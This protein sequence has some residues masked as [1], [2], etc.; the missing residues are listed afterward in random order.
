MTAGAP[1]GSA[2]VRYPDVGSRPL[3]NTRAWWLVGLNFLVPGSAQVLA[4]NRRLGR[5]GLGSTLLFWALV[6]VVVVA[7]LIARTSLLAILLTPVVLWLITAVLAFYGVVWLICTLDTLRLV[8]FVRLGGAVR[9]GVAVLAVAALVLSGGVAF[10]GAW[11]TG[12]TAIVAGKVASNTVDIPGGKAVGPITGAVNLLLVGSDS[13]GGNAAYGTRGETLNDVTILLRISPTS[14]SATALSIPRDLYGSQPACTTSSGE[15]DPPVS[16]ARFNTA[17]ARGGLPCVAGAA[18]AL[19]GL[20]VDYAALIQFDGVVAMSNAVGGVTV[21]LASPINDPYSGLT[22]GAGSQTVQGATALAFL[23]TRKGLSTGSDLQ[24]ISNQQVFLAALMRKVK[25]S[26]T[27]TD[28][29]KLVNLANA[30]ASTMTLSSS[31]AQTSTMVSL[32]LA[33]RDIPLD[34]IAFVQYP[35]RPT[36]IRGQSVTLPIADEAAALTDALKADRAVAV[37]T[38]GSAATANPNASAPTAAPSPSPSATP[39]GGAAVQLPSGVTGQSA[40]QQTC[41]TGSGG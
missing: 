13:G 1:I 10:G 22:L 41:S 28:P 33:L 6:V 27:L 19:T 26:S 24:R 31:L 34:R 15:I 21:C 23:R 3:M 25:D 38:L 29:V 2:P 12:A 11:L 4:G 16:Q 9:A 18:S 7:A 30:A 8:R 14:R 17:L 32:A 40:A 37:G 5:F 39:K 35:T 36:T 20:S